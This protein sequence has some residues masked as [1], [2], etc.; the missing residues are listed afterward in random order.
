MRAR[1]V[2]MCEMLGRAMVSP[3]GAFALAGIFYVF[4]EL[5]GGFQ[6][7]YLNAILAAIGMITLFEPLRDQVGAYIP[8]AL[9]E[10]VDLERAVTRARSALVHVVRVDE[11]HEVVI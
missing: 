3:A 7:M 8:R 4:A 2:D 11:M 9:R 6:T 1:L 5:I 10:R